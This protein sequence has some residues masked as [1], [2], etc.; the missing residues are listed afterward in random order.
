[1]KVPQRT[2]RQGGFT[3]IELI[4]VMVILGILAAFAIPRFAN[5]SAEARH[6]TV[7]GARASV[8]SAATIVRSKWLASGEVEPVPVEGG[9]NVTVDNGYPTA[10]AAGICAAAGLP[11]TNLGCEDNGAGVTVFHRRVDGEDLA[12]SGSTCVFTYALQNPGNAD[13]IVVS[14]TTLADSC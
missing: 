9:I 10:D 3:L 12:T 4:V 8:Q 5:L 7:D 6:A 11:S 2:N 14:E 1:M 13:G